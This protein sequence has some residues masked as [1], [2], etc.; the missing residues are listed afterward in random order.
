MSQSAHPNGLLSHQNKPEVTLG[1]LEVK[2]SVIRVCGTKANQLQ[3]GQ[4]G[5]GSELPP[6]LSTGE[7]QH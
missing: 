5:E 1:Q 4:K 6:V 7:A 3:C 2:F